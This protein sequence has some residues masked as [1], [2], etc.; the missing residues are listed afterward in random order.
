MLAAV[1]NFIIAGNDS[2]REIYQFAGVCAKL[3]R[4]GLADIM[5]STM[6]SK[7]AK[8]AVMY[9]VVTA[10]FLTLSYCWRTAWERFWASCQVRPIVP[11]R[12]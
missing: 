10:L 7:T 1:I 6:P 3:F 2:V 9:R 11:I 4:N 5:V 8:R 12:W